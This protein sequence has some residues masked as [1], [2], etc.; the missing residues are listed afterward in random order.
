M[1]CG[2]R[3]L[4]KHAFSTHTLRLI[5]GL[6]S[7]SPSL[8]LYPISLPV[9]STVVFPGPKR[10]PYG[11]SAPPLRFL[12]SR[13][14]HRPD[15]SPHRRFYRL[16]FPLWHPDTS[17]GVRK[18]HRC[19]ARSVASKF[20]RDE[21]RAGIRHARVALGGQP[22][23]Q[24]ALGCGSA[25]DCEFYTYITHVAYQ[26]PARIESGTATLASWSGLCPAQSAM[27]WF[28]AGPAS[29]TPPCRDS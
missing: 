1:C 21:H 2:R 17:C 16:R 5:V 18:Y 23:A 11:C 12:D 19:R 3:A 7:L 13:V 8:L 4:R 26:R 9:S 25:K 15:A 24:G 6:S 28:I 27:S 14:F 29:A 22:V 20:D 10:S